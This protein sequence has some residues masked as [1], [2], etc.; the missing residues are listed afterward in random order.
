MI[1]NLER[2]HKLGLIFEFKVGEGKLLV[3][4]AKLNTIN[5]K[6]EARQLYRSVIS[7]M[8]SD[9]F[10]PDYPLSDKQLYEIL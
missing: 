2:N 7:Y 5:D 1:D 6:P 9:A 4:M 3:C 8:M 10:N